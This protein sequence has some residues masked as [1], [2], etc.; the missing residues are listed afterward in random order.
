MELDHLKEIW[1][2]EKIDH[3]PEITLEKQKELHTPLEK[4]RRNMRT[5]FW[6]N[7]VSII[8]FI[9]LFGIFSENSFL[10]WTLYLVFVFLVAYYTLK[11]YKIYRKL[12]LNYDTYHQLLELKYE[13]KLNVELYKS[14]YVSSVPFFMGIL[15]LF[16]EKNDFFRY[17]D[18]IMHYAPFIVFFSMMMFMLGF[19]QWWLN[20]FYV[21][22][23]RQYNAVIDELKAP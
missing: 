16:L 23:I 17:P 5:E 8:V 14:Y 22:Y 20:H 11:F 19:G 2:K 13:L 18:L 21:K 9:P 3:F 6:F 10:R 4:L 7:T 15:F 12:N 1:N